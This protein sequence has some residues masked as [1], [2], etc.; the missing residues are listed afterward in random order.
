M[1]RC[2]FYPSVRILDSL[3]CFI[4]SILSPGLCE[5]TKF[6]RNSSDL[7]LSVLCCL[8]GHVYFR[9]VCEVWN[10]QS[11]LVNIPRV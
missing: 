9:C 11:V 5:K 10:F 2:S 7:D 8:S 6:I 1:N 3:T 4:H